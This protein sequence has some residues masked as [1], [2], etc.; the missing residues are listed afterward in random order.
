MVDDVLSKWPSFEPLQA[1]ICNEV[2][3]GRGGR[4]AKEATTAAGQDGGG[5]L[6]RMLDRALAGSHVPVQAFKDQ[7]EFTRYRAQTRLKA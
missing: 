1:L 6:N 2:S 7:D 5:K 3:M 4:T